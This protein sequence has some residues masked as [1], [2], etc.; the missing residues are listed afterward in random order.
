MIGKRGR[1]SA[2]AVATAVVAAACLAPI[3]SAD[4]GPIEGESEGVSQ[5]ILTSPRAALRFWTPASLEAAEPLPIP[6]LPGSPPEEEAAGP[7]QTSFPEE[8]SPAEEAGLTSAESTPSPGG[9]E[10]AAL[11]P[12]AVTQSAAVEGVEVSFAESTLFPNRANGKVYGAFEPEENKLERYECSASVIHSN[13]GNT[14]LTAGHCVMD[15]KTGQVAKYVIF[16]PGYRERSEPYGLWVARRVVTTPSWSTAS[17]NEG[18]DLA[19]LSLL[20]NEGEESIE[21]VVGAL[22]IS[23]DNTCNQVYTQRGYPAE[24]P[25]GGEILYSHAADYAGA[26]TNPLFSPAPIKIATDF[27]RGSSGGPWTIGPSSSPTVVSLTA[28]GYENQPGYLY[29]PYFGE[30]ARKAYD[31][32]SEETVPAG[33]EE[34]CKALPSGGGEGGGGGGGSGSGGGSVE[35]PPATTTPSPTTPGGDTSSGGSS[36]SEA[37]LTLQVTGVN[38]RA[39]GSAVLT[40]KVG[41][42]GM[43]KLSGIAVRPETVSVPAAGNYRM[44][45]SPKGAT[46]RRLRQLGRAK[47]GVKVAFKVSDNI[48]RVSKKIQLSR[49]SAVD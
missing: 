47:V 13:R 11:H 26:D 49:P 41:S 37:S 4:T 31:F 8:E 35:F 25:Y 23:F 46:N 10:T 5:P 7:E 9:A 30:A 19:Y 22:D 16:A 48:R 24:S 33:T 15:E 40:A 32:A 17:S 18:E 44:I 2:G 42:A 21:E 43:L 3:A 12:A 45:V 28:Y 20:D 1:W 27:T 36:S 29:G 38:R 14:V 39:N 6:T 34:A